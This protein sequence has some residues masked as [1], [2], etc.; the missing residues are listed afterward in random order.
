MS[1]LEPALVESVEAE[2]RL[3]ELHYENAIT[4][5][6]QIAKV[7]NEA[8]DPQ[9]AATLQENLA[10]IDRAIAESRAALRTE[11]GSW[12]VQESL[13]EA[14]RRKVSLLGDTIALVNEMRKGNQLEAARI[15]EQLDRP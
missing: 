1:T 13:F 3:A 8:L 5:L 7:Q 15:V 14:L 2:L 4:G 10:V 9:L 6:E 12:L 11:P